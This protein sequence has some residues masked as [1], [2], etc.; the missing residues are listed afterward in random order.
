MTI[1]EPGTCLA[2]TVTWCLLHQVRSFRMRTQSL[3]QSQSPPSLFMWAATVVLYL[4][5]VALCREVLRGSG[6]FMCSSFSI[7]DHRPP[8]ELSSKCVP[9]PAFEESVKIK[10]L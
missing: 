4:F 9:Q 1:S 6:T 2:L 10:M 8:V 7:S 3:T 5:C